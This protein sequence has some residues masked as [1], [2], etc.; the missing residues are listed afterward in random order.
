MKALV[1]EK[2]GQAVIRDVPYPKPGRGEVTIQVKQVGICGTDVHIYKGEFLS[3]YPIIPGHEFSGIIHEIG[4]DVPEFSVGDRVAADP[5]LFCG[6]CSYCL[7]NR[8]NHCENWGALGNTVNGSMAEY[9]KVPYENLVRMPDDMSYEEGAFIEPLACVVYAM[10]RLQMKVGDQ[11]LLFGAGA[12]GQQLIQSMKAAGASTLAVIDLSEEKLRL[13]KEWGATHTFTNDE[14]D[15]VRHLQPRGFD[16]VVDATGIP[17][18]IEEAITFTGPVGKYLQ[19]GVTPADASIKMNPFD[20]YHKDWTL[21][22]TMAIN[23][24]FIPAFNWLKEKRIQVQPL[25]S[26]T[27]SLEDTVSFLEGPRDPDLLKVQIKL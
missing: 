18:V 19:F 15:Q 25:I 22:G 11:V 24:T 1:I 27:I 9:V 17:T 12:M 16:I 3:P 23:H 6:K 2:P 10:Y 14:L 8:G 21:L 20:L 26:K 5:S 13:A 7:T 4:E